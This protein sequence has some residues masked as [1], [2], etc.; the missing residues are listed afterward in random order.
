LPFPIPIFRSLGALGKAIRAD[1]EQE[2]QM[3]R[4]LLLGA[5][6]LCAGALF[7]FGLATVLQER[8]MMRT[9]SFAAP[10]APD[11]PSVA[12]DKRT[13]QQWMF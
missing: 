11:A 7:T 3:G 6:M 2:H 8:A 13:D 9:S 12:A 5:L 4:K 1:W 10:Y